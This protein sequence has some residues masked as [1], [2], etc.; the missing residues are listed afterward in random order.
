MPNPVVHWEIGSPDAS[1]ARDFYEKAFGWETTDA[2]SD[3][4]LVAPAGAGLGGGIM[5]TRMGMPAYVTIYVQVDDL[6]AKLAE[7]A[8]LGGKTIVAP[9]PISPAASFAMFCDP[10]GN[11]VGLLCTQE[12]VAG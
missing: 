3:Y 12:L 10:S 1:Q 2:S 4:T 8:A 5:Q 11:I 7:I 9:A 6:D